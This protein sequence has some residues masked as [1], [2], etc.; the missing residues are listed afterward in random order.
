MYSILIG[1]VNHVQI[2]YNCTRAHSPQVYSQGWSQV[3]KGDC[4]QIPKKV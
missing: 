2:D 4:L 3:T 1:D